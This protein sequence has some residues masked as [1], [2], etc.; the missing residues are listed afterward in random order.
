VTPYLLAFVAGGFFYIAA[1][2][3]IPELNKEYTGKKTIIITLIFI[4]GIALMWL[5]K[6]VLDIE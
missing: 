5:F 2:D 6:L 3:L 4:G 1:S